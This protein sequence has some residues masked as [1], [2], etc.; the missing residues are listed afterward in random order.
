MTESTER[1]TATEQGVAWGDHPGDAER[2]RL[3]RRPRGRLRE[4]S[5]KAFEEGD[6]VDGYGGE[7]RPRRGPA[8]HRL[9]VRGRHPLA[10]A[11]H[12][13]RRRP[14]RGRAAWATRSRPWSCT[15]EDKDGRLVLSK[16]RAQYE[17]AWGTI[18]KIKENDGGRRGPGHR[19]RQGRPDPRHRPA[20]LPPGLARRAA[21]C[22]RPAALRRP[23]S[24]E[25]KIIELDKNRNNVVLSRRAWLEE[26]Q[27]ESRDG[28]SSHNLQAGRGPQGRGVER[29]QLRC[30]RRPR[31]HGRPHPR[32]RAVVE[33]RR[34]PGLRVVAV[35]DEVTVQV[36][37]VDLEPRAASACRS[38]PP[39]RI[40]GREFASSHQVG[41]LV[42][43]RVPKLVPFGAFVQVGDGIEGLVHISEMVGAPRRLARAGRHARRG[44]RGSRS[45]TSTS[46]AAASACRS[47]R[48]PRT[49]PS[50]PPPR[51]SWPSRRAPTRATRASTPRVP[52]S[53]VP[54]AEG[55]YADGQAT[56]TTS[57]ATPS[58]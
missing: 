38:R 7:G 31:R 2:R 9:Q 23:A 57:R 56:S 52:M 47:S 18:E 35:G 10:R 51:T 36:L 42:Y 27:K 1:P 32:V 41:E 46:S 55:D 4:E 33:A 12:P 37:D 25:A 3:R 45:S 53:R 49:R 28:R 6:I 20:G 29:R 43:G 15:K 48:P 13:Q 50:S 26:T 34:P 54:T 5:L 58:A 30:L 39:S 16:K 21:P 44:A 14:Q 24:C 22:A 40:R 11:V 19:G 17:R 8:R